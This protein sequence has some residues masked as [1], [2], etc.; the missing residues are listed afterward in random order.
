ME[1]MPPRSLPGC[2]CRRPRR[3]GVFGSTPSARREE[4]GSGAGWSGRNPAQTSGV[5]E[6]KDAEGSRSGRRLA[7]A[8]EDNGEGMFHA[9]GGSVR[10]LG[11]VGAGG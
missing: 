3:R 5:D 11:R 1:A 9:G 7:G 4:E 2:R 8:A 10:D 6:V